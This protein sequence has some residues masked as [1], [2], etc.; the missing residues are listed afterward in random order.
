MLRLFTRYLLPYLLKRFI[1][2]AEKKYSTGYGKSQAPQQREGETHINYVPNDYQQKE[3]DL[4]E[5]VDFEDIDDINDK[6]E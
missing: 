4:G 3:N 5:Y 6:K 2:N 1:R